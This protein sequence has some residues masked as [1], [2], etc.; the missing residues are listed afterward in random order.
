MLE[1]GADFEPAP[2]FVV[3]SNQTGDANAENVPA[4]PDGA[5][6]RTIAELNVTQ[7]Q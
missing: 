5:D 7:T 3:R 1:I 4:A 2:A 6:A